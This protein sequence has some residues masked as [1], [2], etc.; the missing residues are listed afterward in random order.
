MYSISCQDLA[1]DFNA[2]EEPFLSQNTQRV[3][4]V[5]QVFRSF[6]FFLKAGDGSLINSLGFRIE[7]LG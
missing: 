3:G 2:A 1:T 4:R 6:V 7:S 5:T